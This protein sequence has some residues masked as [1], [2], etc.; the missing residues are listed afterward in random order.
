MWTASWSLERAGTAPQR[1]HTKLG[2]T[3]LIGSV[4]AAFWK[5]GVLQ[6]VGG[7]WIAIGVTILGGVGLRISAC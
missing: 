5:L 4:L 2:F 6:N 3:I 1:S 7:A